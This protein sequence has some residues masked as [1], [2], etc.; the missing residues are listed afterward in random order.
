MKQDEF[1][2]IVSGSTTLLLDDRE[3]L[4][5][6]GDCCGFKAGTGVG[7]QLVN[8]SALP[9]QYLEVGDPTPDDYAEYPEDNLK[10][11]QTDDRS[12]IL[13]RKDGTPY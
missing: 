4:L 2:Y 6:P 1:I 13:T 10:F 12:W 7:H 9:V 5:K 3:Y 11:T 8:R